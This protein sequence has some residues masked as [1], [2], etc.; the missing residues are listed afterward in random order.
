MRTGDLSNGHQSQG[1]QG[2]V[3]GRAR[4][5]CT[6]E[7]IAFDEVAEVEAANRG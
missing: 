4:G 6:G 3:T 5:L 2:E 7:K 1:A